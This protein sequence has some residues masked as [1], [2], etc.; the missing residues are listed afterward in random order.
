MKITTDMFRRSLYNIGPGFDLQPM[1]R[2]THVTDVFMYVNL[3]LWQEDM[4]DWYE[5]EFKRYGIEVRGKEVISDF[6]ETA[7]FEL[8]PQYLSHLTQPDFLTQHEA[9]MYWQSFSGA[10]RDAQFALVYTLYR[11]SVDREFTLIIFY[12]EGLASYIA[13]SHNGLYAPR[14]LCTVQTGVLEHPDSL[15]NRFF[16]R[17]GCAHPE[18][19]VR[20]FE[21]RRYGWIPVP[22]SNVLRSSG[23]FNRKVLDFN[24]KWYV[25]YSYRGQ[26]TRV[27]HCKGFT[28]EAGFERMQR[29]QLRQEFAGGRHRISTERWSAEGCGEQ[30]WLVVSRVW[31]RLGESFPAERTLFWEDFTDL[32]SSWLSRGIALNVHELRVRLKSAKVPKDATLHVIPAFFEDEGAAWLRHV[33]N[34]PQQTVLY[35][36]GLYDVIDFKSEGV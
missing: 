22:E 10:K 32:P 24:L 18:L 20:G 9:Q 12:G 1:L 30:D 35:A 7:H 29:L 26:H 23:V 6:D 4:E 28:T 21:P 31:T 25:G 13:L 2:F 34:F 3:Y 17:P 14:V 36:P 8:H 15:M 11:E 19:W 16:E 27:R 33:Q 5:D